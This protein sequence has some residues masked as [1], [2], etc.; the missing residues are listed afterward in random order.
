M[1]NDPSK[2]DAYLA[3]L[4]DVSFV[5]DVR[6]AEMAPRVRRGPQPDARIVVR[7]PSGERSFLLAIKGICPSLKYP[8]HVVVLPLP[9]TDALGQGRV[10]H[11]VHEDG[12][13][14]KPVEELP[15]V[16]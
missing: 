3:R 16:A 6:L 13:L 2:L 11:R 7:T 5:E 14:Q 15:A 4:R 12:L 8:L 10:G 1:R 9:A